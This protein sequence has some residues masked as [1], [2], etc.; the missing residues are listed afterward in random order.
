MP[1]MVAAAVEREELLMELMV[2]GVYSLDLAVRYETTPAR[3][4]PHQQSKQVMLLM[5]VPFHEVIP[6]RLVRTTAGHPRPQVLRIRVP[7]LV[8][9]RAQ[10][11]MMMLGT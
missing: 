6:P 9:Q 1:N 8:Q 3:A 4:D 11:S 7:K 10:D 2:K 5:P